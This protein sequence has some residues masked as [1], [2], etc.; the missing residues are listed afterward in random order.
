M[1]ELVAASQSNTPVSNSQA[2]LGRHHIDEADDVT[3]ATQREA[4]D[5]IDHST[6]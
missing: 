6:L 1:A 2:V 3:L 4:L 5:G